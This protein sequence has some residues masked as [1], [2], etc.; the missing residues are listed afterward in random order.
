MTAGNPFNYLSISVITLFPQFIAKYSEFG[1]FRAALAQGK[2]QLNVINLR[3]F[4]IDDH[5]SVDAPP[6]GGGDGM[7]LRCEPLKAALESIPG[8]PRVIL[9]S[10]SG[11]KWN[12]SEAMTF[13]LSSRPLVFVCGRFGGIDQR[14]IDR[15]VDDEIC[16][17][18]YVVSGGELPVLTMIDSVLRYVPGVL[19]NSESC[20]NDSFAEG[21]GG[22][23]EH[24][25][26]TRPKEF[27]GHSVP[28]ILLSGDHKKID[29]WRRKQSLEI[30]AQKRP[31]LLIKTMRI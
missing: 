4:A 28:E 3:D 26:Y 23:L 2:M 27:E 29:Q 10:A 12:A 7:V 11:R 8:Q 17:G 1:V 22:L 31:D 25:L 6:Y 30:T 19:G 5:G 18:D 16:I 24:P 13:S 15:Y 14:F 21:T 9:A 20:L